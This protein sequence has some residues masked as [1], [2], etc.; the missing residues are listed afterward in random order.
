VPGRTL[1]GRVSL[2]ALAVIASWVLVVAL[3]FDVVAVGR[4]DR[5]LD[6]VLRLRAQ[7]ASTLLAVHDGRVVGVRESMT[8]EQLDAGVWIYATPEWRAVERPSVSAR[9]H[10]IADRLSRR[11][12]GFVSAA[13]HRFYVLPVG[14]AGRRLATVVTASSTEAQEDSKA[15]VVLGSVVLA[16]LIVA[17]AFPVLRLAVGRAL[18]PVSGMADQAAEWSS[19]PGRERFGSQ[20]YAEL[21]RLARNLD[22]LL[23]RIDALLRHERQLSGEL[24]HELRTPLTRLLGEIELLERQV[25]PELRAALAGMRDSCLAMNAIID[26]ALATTR[27]ELVV[28]AARTPLA[29][30]LRT[31]A[32][33]GPP[34]VRVSATDLAVGVEAVIV[35][36]ILNALIDNARR[37]AVEGIWLSAREVDGQVELR[38]VNDGPPVAVSDAER[39]FEPGF[40]R[41]SNGHG[42]AGLGLPL[43]RRLAHAADGDL[44]LDL[45]A[46][47]TCFTLRLPRG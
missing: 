17:G 19:A 13:G 36:R 32:T 18:R 11:P 20:R 41:P 3:A 45:E 16:L 46:P 40:S 15:T 38:V 7:A 26:A 35:K 4:I 34:R 37:Y 30:V 23:N 42:G 12:V 25:G 10:R 5:Q 43:A 21:Q 28:Q 33:A 9:L 27:A 1:R 6:D 29:D 44:A 2:L 14:A 8:D 24:S 22:G 39:I 47:Q 31:Y